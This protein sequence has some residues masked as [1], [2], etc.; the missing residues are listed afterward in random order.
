MLLL[1]PEVRKCGSEKEEAKQN[2]LECSRASNTQRPDGGPD[3][4]RVCKK[5]VRNEFKGGETAEGALGSLFGFG[6]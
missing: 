4:L 6:W 1:A 5:C 2:K 3:E